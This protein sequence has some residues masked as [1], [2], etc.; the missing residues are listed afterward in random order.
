MVTTF[1]LSWSQTHKQTNI[2]KQ[3]W[4]IA[5]NCATK[6]SAQCKNVGDESDKRSLQSL[7][8][9][10]FSL[11]LFTVYEMHYGGQLFKL[12]L[13]AD[14]LKKHFERRHAVRRHRSLL[15]DFSRHSD[16]ARHLVNETKQNKSPTRANFVSYR[17]R[18]KGQF[19]S[20]ITFFK[21]RVFHSPADQIPIGI[22]QRR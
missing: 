8:S 12:Y 13:S 19:L 11:K 3:T 1:E 16:Q 2:H 14:S 9:E 10:K 5:I 4:P 20:K 15:Y 22:L 21:S 6:L 17:F 18:D 7:D